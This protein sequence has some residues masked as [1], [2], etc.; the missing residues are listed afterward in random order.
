MTLILVSFH[1]SRVIC[2]GGCHI[3]LMVHREGVEDGIQKSVTFVSIFEGGRYL[4]HIYTSGLVPAASHV[5]LLGCAKIMMSCSVKL[6]EVII[7]WRR[8]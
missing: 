8:V 6:T 5:Q 4:L 3:C 7:G 2:E 1:G